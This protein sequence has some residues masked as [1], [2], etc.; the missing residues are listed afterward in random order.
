M[1]N[2]RR[3]DTNK[4]LAVLSTPGQWWTGI[5]H[6]VYRAHPQQAP[7]LIYRLLP[8][9][10]VIVGYGMV[11]AA[12]Y[13]GETGPLL[14]LL[15][16][17]VIL[18]SLGL[19]R[20]TIALRENTQQIQAALR[21]NDELQRSDARFR[22]LVQ[23]AS[24]VITVIT[25]DGTITYDSPA[26]VPILGYATEARV[27]KR[28]WD[29]IHCDDLQIFYKADAAHTPSIHTMD[30]IEVRML[31]ADGSWLWVEAKLTNLL[32]DPNVG[33]IVANYRD[34]RER[35]RFEEQLR[36]LAYHDPLTNV[37]NR[38][39]FHKQL[40]TVFAAAHASGD[41]IAVFLL[42]LDGFKLVNDQYGHSVGDQMLIVVGQRIRSCLRKDDLVARLGGDEFAILLDQLRST[43]DAV[44]IAERI[45]QSLDKPLQIEDQDLV[46]R[47]SIGI[48]LYQ[49]GI[50]SPEIL[51]RNAD[52]AM[53]LAKRHGKGRYALFASAE[54]RSAA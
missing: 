46:V 35:K 53:Y 43:A 11:V 48:A 6:L 24:D 19:I 44:K 49:P 23:N 33:G 16:G 36:H 10:A 14:W 45:I 29:F 52:R 37:A 31:H 22:S 40:S 47:G 8:Y 34:I 1:V 4:L 25:A 54:T 9:L 30:S 32:H 7:K 28:I 13:L 38:T 12:V 3:L 27:G 15:I 2:R 17:A 21:L 5:S 20:Q 18:T 41:L 26:L 50:D 39:L 51:L 42:D